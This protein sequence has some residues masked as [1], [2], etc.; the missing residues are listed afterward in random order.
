MERYVGIDFGT[1]N[2]AIAL[3]EG[4]K[5]KLS[6]YELFGEETLSFRSVLYLSIDE[7]ESR[8]RPGIFAGPSAIEQYLDEGGSGRIIQSLKNFLPNSSFEWTQV[9]ATKFTLEQLIGHLLTEMRRQVEGQFGSIGHSAVVG[10]PV[11]FAHARGREQEELALDRLRAAY[12]IAGF[13]EVTFVS[14]R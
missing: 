5:V 12:A 8:T 4:S 13:E 10:R 2:S 1:T 14:S 6:R 3:C 11:R 7:P 9:L